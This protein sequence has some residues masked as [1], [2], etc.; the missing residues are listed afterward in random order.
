MGS[1]IRVVEILKMWWLRK[2]VLHTSIIRFDSL[3]C[4]EKHR[5]EVTA[6]SSRR[7]QFLPAT[8]CFPFFRRIWS[9]VWRRNSRSN[10]NAD[11]SRKGRSHR[12]SSTTEVLHRLLL[13]NNTM[14]SNKIY[15][16]RI[17]F[18]PL[19]I[20][21][22]QNGKSSG[23]SLLQI[24]KVSKLFGCRN[25]RY[26]YLLNSGLDNFIHICKEK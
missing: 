2:I 25:C 8:D 11:H 9:P 24:S 22:I 4:V 1:T 20:Y 15:S 3:E 14:A 13:S 10:T 26:K 6:N 7:M 21:E 16:L 18:L 5:C 19:R 12:F 17:L 23:I